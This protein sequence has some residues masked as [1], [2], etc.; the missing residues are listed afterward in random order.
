MRPLELKV[1]GLH[2]YRDPVTV[3]FEV[4][5]RFGLFGIFGGI[6]SGKS[7]LLDAMTLALFGLV[8]RTATRSRRGLIHPAVGRCEVALRFAVEDGLDREVY[9]IQRAYKASEG[10]AARVA[11]R[12]VQIDDDGSRVVLTEKE[13]ETNQ[14]I[15]EII[16]LGA[17][18]F[19]RAVVLPQG[20]FL[21]LLQ[22]KG[23][24]RR[25][26]LQRIFKLSAF[27]EGLR[28]QIRER[29]QSSRST[30]ASVRGELTGIGNASQEAIEEAEREAKAARIEDEEA[31]AA[32]E[33]SREAYEIASRHRERRERIRE[34]EGALA[35]HLVDADDHVAR[36]ARLEEALRVRPLFDPA[37]RWREATER[38]NEREGLAARAAEAA[39]AATAAAEAAKQRRA[40][41]VALR[42]A[43]APELAA[44]I[45]Q[46]EAVVGWERERE[47]LRGEERAAAQ[48][49]AEAAQHLE[50]AQRE[51]RAARTRRA[52]LE[53]ERG[54]AKREHD[55]CKVTAQEREAIRR[56]VQAAEA[57]AAAD[58]LCAE[59]DE[60]VAAAVAEEEAAAEARTAA[61]TALEACRSALVEKEDAAAVA[62]RNPAA[63]SPPDR[64]AL[65]VEIS[66]CEAAIARA[67]A[68]AAALDAA[69][70]AREQASERAAALRADAERAEA[71]R[72]AAGSAYQSAEV[73]VRSAEEEIEALRVRSAAADL[74]RS[75]APGDPCPVCGSADHPAPAILT[76]APP[77]PSLADK[78]RALALALTEHQTAVAAAASAAA[79]AASAEGVLAEADRQLDAALAGEQAEPDQRDRLDALLAK[80]SAADAA[81]VAIAEAT[82]A[83]RD[84][85]TA[86]ERA[87]LPHALAD[88][89]LAT[90]TE[91]SERARSL[92]TERA[93]QASTARATFEGLGSEASPADA[94]SA[95][96]ALDARDRQAEALAATL[97]ALDADI[98]ACHATEASQRTALEESSAALARARERLGSVRQQLAALDE[99]IAQQALPSPATD[100]L[101]AANAELEGLGE[102]VQ[103]ADEAAIGAATALERDARAR[104][105]A[106]AEANAARTEHNAALTALIQIARSHAPDLVVAPEARRRERVDAILRDPLDEDEIA[107]LQVEVA[108]WEERRIALSSARDALLGGEPLPEEDTWL[109]VS[110]AH[111]A[112]TERA[113]IARDAAIHTARALQA[114]Q[115]KAPRFVALTDQS[116]TLD[117]EIGQLDELTALLRGDRFVEFV[118]NDHLSELTTRATAHLAAL[119][120]GRFRLRLDDDLAFAIEDR[121]A[122]NAVRPVHSLSGGESFL[123]ALALALAL[124][125]QVQQRS[126]RPLGFFFLDEGFGT[127]DPDA[128]DRVMTA[129]ENLRTEH[130]LIGLISH[131]AAVR[132]RVP[133]YLWV[134]PPTAATGSRVEIRDT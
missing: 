16:G 98:A 28:R 79:G 116:A 78:R 107:R 68:R 29:N 109:A 34:A 108:A 119:T 95:L 130:R 84:A 110:E 124:S 63:L 51:E 14:A 71:D 11:S 3:D 96:D 73:A 61:A 90:A 100:A 89:A 18:D 94:S 26:M 27:G 83:Q 58:R 121:D 62:E 6:G 24:E 45:A 112:A 8:D 20:R 12:L 30:L 103:R 118:A 31:E 38:R 64:R 85:A 106:E 129:I 44:R 56:T 48:G 49:E 52:A 120:H 82:A 125:A 4:L 104:D 133:R 111:A 2:S 67:Q 13:T 113:R 76:D 122:G 1:Q 91:R 47:A 105:A 72:Q 80:R 32:L 74:A 127:L 15:V 50:A 5:G 77:L 9:E 132:E 69:R 117:R 17:E 35:G 86:V 87:T 55:Q 42:D 123:T 60:A 41:E 88:A 37:S 99:R 7:T 10:V 131:I 70:A 21:H 97:D 114:L 40:A 134:H 93:A 66:S 36:K 115:R 102:A 65:D 101:A 25:Q 59:A 54:Q 75:L 43:R 33:R 128:L 81:A 53:S 19:M 46:L 39:D 126:A 92:A 22:L 23:A 57:V